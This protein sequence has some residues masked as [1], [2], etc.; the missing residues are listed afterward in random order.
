MTT[1]YT[2]LRSPLGPLLLVGD[3]TALTG[4]FL[5]DHRR[6]R[7]VQSD[8]RADDGPF[9]DAAYQLGE[10]FAGDRTAFTLPLAPGGTAFQA[11]VWAGLRA[12]RYGHTTTYGALAAAIGAP[13]AVR[14]VAGAVG[15]NPVSI[16]VGCHR[17]VGAGGGLVGYAGG[18]AAKAWLLAHERG[19]SALPAL[20]GSRGAAD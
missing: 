8:W 10:Y 7:T 4:L 17:V 3:G 6:G 12:V 14:A 19:E 16:V 18:L 5:P 13:S 2:H 1:W 15:R 9:R 20:A 11:Q